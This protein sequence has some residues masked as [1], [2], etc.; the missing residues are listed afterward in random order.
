[1]LNIGIRLSSRCISKVC[2]LPGIQNES[3]HIYLFAILSKYGIYIYICVL[4][5]PNRVEWTS[6]KFRI[7]SIFSCHVWL[8]ML[9]ISYILVFG[10]PLYNSYTHN[11]TLFLVQTYIYKK[12]NWNK[13]KYTRKS[14]IMMIISKN[15]YPFFSVD[16]AKKK[17]CDSYGIINSWVVHQTRYVC[18]FMCEYEGIVQSRVIH[19]IF[20][21]FSEI[22]I[23]I[24]LNRKYR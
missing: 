2:V 19:F 24:Y 16:I 18:E 13:K 20:F 17:N 3:K 23:P 10:K 15:D 12:R 5:W 6:V 8:Y 7:R 4:A 22:N 1:M 11:L 9:A 14:I 21:Y